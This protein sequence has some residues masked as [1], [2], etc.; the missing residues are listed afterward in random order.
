MND[1]TKEQVKPDGKGR[2][3]AQLVK[4]DLKVFNASEVITNWREMYS[5]LLTLAVRFT[6]R[7]T[8]IQDVEER[9]QLGEKRY[10]ERLRAFNSRDARLDLYQEVLDALMYCRQV[11]EEGG[12]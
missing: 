10:G 7:K 11:I 12:E 9:A 4:D 1:A 3:I 8:V 2:E 5:I 6:D